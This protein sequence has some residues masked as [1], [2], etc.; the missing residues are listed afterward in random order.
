MFRLSVEMRTSVLHISVLKI[1]ISFTVPLL[2]SAQSFLIQHQLND[3]TISQ[4]RGMAASLR[5]GITI[6]RAGADERYIPA[7][8]VLQLSMVEHKQV[9]LLHSLYTSTSSA[10]RSRNGI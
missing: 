8:K 6:I 1:R 4:A 10:Q 5:E 9:R 7:D 3:L 2:T